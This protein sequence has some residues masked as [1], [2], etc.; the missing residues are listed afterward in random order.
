MTGHLTIW[1]K[2]KKRESAGGTASTCT[3]SFL[4]TAVLR[5]WSHRMC[6]CKAQLSKNSKS[7]SLLGWEDQCNCPV[8]PIWREGSGEEYNACPLKLNAALVFLLIML[9]AGMIK[10]AG[11]CKGIYCTRPVVS[12][13]ACCGKM[14]S[15]RMNQNQRAERCYILSAPSSTTHA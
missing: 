2:E 7:G 6:F 1:Q 13:W 3:F 4:L 12:V 10:K 11:E 15:I 9:I 5:L 14:R 8:F